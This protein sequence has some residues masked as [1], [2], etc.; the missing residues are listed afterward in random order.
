MQKLKLIILIMIVIISTENGISQ[1]NRQK[2]KM[3]DAKHGKY[4]EPGATKI[5]PVTIFNH[6]FTEQNLLDQIETIRL[7]ITNN[8]DPSLEHFHKIYSNQIPLLAQASAC[9]I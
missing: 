4:L 3:A 6:A 1:N 5:H 2:N 8:T 7:N 9:A